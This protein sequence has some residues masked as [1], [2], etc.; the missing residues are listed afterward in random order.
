VK[1]A[2]ITIFFVIDTVR[3]LLEPEASP[4][5]PEKLYPVAGVAVNCTVDPEAYDA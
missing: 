1:V 4:L 3:G 2:V 5:H